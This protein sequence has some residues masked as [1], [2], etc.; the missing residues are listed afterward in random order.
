MSDDLAIE[1]AENGFRVY[2]RVDEGG[3]ALRRVSANWDREDDTPEKRSDIEVVMR[4]VA[5]LRLDVAKSCGTCKHY[6]PGWYN[7]SDKCSRLSVAFNIDMNN[8]CAHWEG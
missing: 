7:E 3:A 1:Y 5:T 4:E 2:A 8:I 6:D